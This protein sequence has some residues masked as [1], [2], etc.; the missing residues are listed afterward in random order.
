M[1]ERLLPCT[2][3]SA[4]TRIKVERTLPAAGELLVQVG[5]TVLASQV[6]ARTT[7]QN[8]VYVVNVKGILN[9]DDLD[10]SHVMTKERGDRVQTGE[11][12]AARPGIL[13]FLHKPCRSP[14]SGEMKDIAYGWAL[15]E[16]GAE[17]L[18]VLAFIPGRVTSVVPHRSATIEAIGAVIEGACGIGKEATGVLKIP[19]N[20]RTSQVSPDDIGE[21]FNKTIVVAGAEVSSEMLEQARQV[22][23]AGL[24]AGGMNSSLLG[25]RAP[26]PVVATEGYGHRPMSQDVFDILKGLE[27]QQVSLSAR[28]GQP[29]DSSRPML[30]APRAEASQDETQALAN[31]TRARP[32]RVG[33]KVRAVRSPLSGCVGQI[34]SMPEEPRRTASGLILTGALVSFPEEEA[35]FDA[36]DEWSPW[37]NLERMG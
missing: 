22:G 27:G 8:E 6:I 25:Q 18:D 1:A 11:T 29:W 7:G 36:R 14:V 9:M 31:D 28:M 15:I 10:L 19:I 16:T 5:E 21:A 30:I 32:V 35:T 24:I 34:K 17:Q 23:V 2:R 3:S 26:L 33:D 13:P 4:L 37:L 12:I 20:D